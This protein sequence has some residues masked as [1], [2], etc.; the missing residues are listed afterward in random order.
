LFRFDETLRAGH[1]GIGTNQ[2]QAP[3][4]VCTKGAVRCS[5]RG[6]VIEREDG[7][8]LLVTIH[9]SY[10]LRIEDARSKAVEYR[11]FVAD[12]RICAEALAKAA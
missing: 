7:T 10:L 1:G 9:P 8:R 6:N 2:A 12:L 5:A 3:L 11:H 4:D